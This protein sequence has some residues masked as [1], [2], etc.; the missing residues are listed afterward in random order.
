MA[1]VPYSS[2][3]P[4]TLQQLTVDKTK[5]GLSWL[6]DYITAIKN[7]RGPTGTLLNDLA[8]AS[9]DAADCAII[10]AVVELRLDYPAEKWRNVY[11]ALIVLEFLLKRGG[12]QCVRLAEDLIAKLEHLGQFAYISVDGRDQGVNVRHRAQAVL[13]LMRDSNRLQQEREAFA[14]KRKAYQGFTRDQMT[15]GAHGRTRSTGARDDSDIGSPAG[16]MELEEAE[17]RFRDHMSHSAQQKGAPTAGPAGR[18]EQVAAGFLQGALPQ[19]LLEYTG[20]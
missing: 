10:F 9:H 3:R 4:A 16:R 8:E 14:H 11:K 1:L 13:L 12:S 7:G 20:K 15:R 17:A 19:M 5:E 2:S 18:W 6:R